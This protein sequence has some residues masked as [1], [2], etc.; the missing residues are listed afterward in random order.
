M[1]VIDVKWGKKYNIL[2]V[3]CSKCGYEF[4]SRIDRWK[5]KCPTCKTTGNTE[6]M[7]NEFVRRMKDARLG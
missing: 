6:K 1:K 5:V 3:K 2:R 4:N 7:R